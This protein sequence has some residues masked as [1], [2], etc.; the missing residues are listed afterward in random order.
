MRSRPDT[1]EIGIRDREI[2]SGYRTVRDNSSNRAVL[3]GYGLEPNT[4]SSVW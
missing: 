4:R 1:I 2:E 3:S